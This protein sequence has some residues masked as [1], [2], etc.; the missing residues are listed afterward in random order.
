MTD[1]LRSALAEIADRAPVAQVPDSTYRRGRRSHARRV[2]AG[3]MAVVLVGLGL[4][5][6]VRATTHHD[7]PVTH[8]TNSGA[9]PSQLYEVPQRLTLTDGHG[10]WTG[11]VET[12][13]AIGVGS[14]AWVS[15]VGGPA[16]LVTATDGDYH[17]LD[18]PGF[19]GK[20]FGLAALGPALA[21]SPDG[22][23][24]AYAWSAS[25][26]LG[27]KTQPSGV[28]VVDLVTGTP[29]TIAIR[30]DGVGTLVQ[31]IVWSPDSRWL[32]WYGGTAR[33]ASALHG[34]VRGL[35]AP[36]ATT[37]TAL[38]SPRDAATAMGVDNTG[39]VALLSTNQT[40][41]VASSGRVEHRRKALPRPT[42]VMAD[43]QDRVSFTAGGSRLAMPTYTVGGTSAVLDLPSG[44]T[45]F[46][47]FPD[48]PASGRASVQPLG[49]VD[50]RHLVVELSPAEGAPELVVIESPND[51]FASV[52][53]VTRFQTSLLSLSVAV[54][55]MNPHRYTADL[56]APDW[57]WSTERKLA[58]VSALVV[59]IGLVLWVALGLTRRRWA[60]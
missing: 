51:D 26:T 27:D 35:I 14:V 34:S 38:P 2:A 33:S 22:R 36:G 11:P 44:Q 25:G 48:P 9:V 60:H 37:S 43:A 57:P 50:D 12:N 56:P 1:R 59:G 47:P 29:R 4:G 54:D 6:A 55:L 16:V 30:T 7:L 45:L 28:R 39:K 15:S 49:W 18:P 24:L 32:A 53:T 20:D 17:L 58:V 40:L 8:R 13:L 19:L 41:L 31:Q 46:H 3:A 42:L 10:R 5:S 23:S 52:R 21:L